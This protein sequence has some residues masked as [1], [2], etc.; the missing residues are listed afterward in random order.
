MKDGG[1]TLWHMWRFGG[2]RKLALATVLLAAVLAGGSAAAQE[3][4]IAPARPNIVFFLMDDA[5]REDLYRMENVVSLLGDR[6]TTFTNGIITDAVCCPSRTTILRGQ[7]VHNHEVKEVVPP[8]GGARRFNELGLGNST[9]ATWLHDEGYRTALVGKYLNGHEG[10]VPPGWDRWTAMMGGQTSNYVDVQGKPVARNGRVWDAMFSSR[11][12]SFV[13]NN[14]GGDAPFFLY[15]GFAAPHFGAGHEERYDDAFKRASLPRSPSFNEAD[16]SDKPAYLRRAPALT[17]S[18]IRNLVLTNRE[19]YRSVQTADEGIRKI[20]SAVARAGEL[21]NT[22]FFF[23]TDNGYHL[24]EHA[25]TKGKETAY[26]EDADFPLIVR[27]PG[28]AQGA[29]RDELVLTND[30]APTWADLAGVGVPNF[31]DGRSM[32]PLLA[33]GDAPWRDAALV[34]GYTDHTFAGLPPYQS[35]RTGDWTYTEYETGEK[36]LYDLTADTYQLESKHD[37]PAYADEEAALAARLEALEGCA[38]QT[39]REAENAPQDNST[40]TTTP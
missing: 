12:L 9:V 20:I 31:V 6:G 16:R 21:D 4:I 2:S 35:V 14:A 32:A 8:D 17:R 36:E 27:G 33:G 5:R 15:A 29:Q 26:V 1:C 3:T 30:F 13:E 25:M 11:A 40:D 22:Y 10:G 34:E 19:R 18:Q 28:V 37:D 39:C 23:F 7:Y 24:G 38:A